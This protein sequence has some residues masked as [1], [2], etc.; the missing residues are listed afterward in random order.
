MEHLLKKIVV[1]PSRFNFRYKRV[2]VE[3][4]SPP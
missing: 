2:V 3:S 4:V 1:L